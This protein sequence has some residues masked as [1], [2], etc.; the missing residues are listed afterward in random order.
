MFT[1]LDRSL[2]RS[3]V[4]SYVICFVSLIGLYVV[5]DLFTHIDDFMQKQ[6]DFWEVTLNILQFYGYRI[7]QI[8]DRLCEM[9]VLLAAMFTIAWV[10]RNN[11]LL[12]LL[13]AGVSTRRV[14]R[15]VLFTAAGFLTL[16][17]LNQELVIPRIATAL[18]RTHDDPEGE[19]DQGVR[20]AFD[21]NKVYLSGQT[22]SRRGFLVRH[23]HCI[24]PAE[25]GPG[26]LVYIDAKEANY[27]PPDPDHPETSGGWLLH[28]ATIKP[29][30]AAVQT[31]V[32][33]VLNSDT[34]FLRTTE[35]DFDVVTRDNKWFYLASTLR[36][37]QELNKPEAQKLGSIAV[38]FH[39]RLT[40]PLLGLILLFLGLSVILRDQNRNVFISAGLCILMCAAFYAVGI[41]CRE[42]GDKD[43]LAPALAAWLPVLLFGPLAF[44]LFDAIHT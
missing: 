22:A 34:Y 30:D 3:Y 6:T 36:L 13:S 23:F 41:A 44:V 8:F 39:T 4:K 11:E 43:F 14:L 18:L 37:F 24:I 40:R 33:T 35:V 42:L 27:I 2:V 7:I 19:K 15:P 31:D 29:F 32:L 12:P 5:I 25:L 10:Q 1:L 26:T 20:G 16:S 9:I 38:V 21:T 28:E 17:V